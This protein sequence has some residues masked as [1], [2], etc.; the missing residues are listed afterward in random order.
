M[1]ARAGAAIRPGPVRP[2]GGYW[3]RAS[4]FAGEG[5]SG[6]RVTMK[7]MVAMLRV[8]MAA[9]GAVPDTASAAQ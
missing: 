7:I 6:N 8:P 5:F 4:F 2:S 9:G 3:C 1:G